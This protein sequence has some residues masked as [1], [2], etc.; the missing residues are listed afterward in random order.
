MKTEQAGKLKLVEILLLLFLAAFLATGALALQT[1]QEL[2][3][4]VV[5]LHV[6]ANSDSEEDQAL[7]LQV[8]DRVLAYAEP[9]LAGAADRR[10]AEALLRGRVL[11]LERIAAEE[12]RTEG[13]DYAVT[14]E[15]EDTVFPTREYEDFTLPAGKYLALRVVIGA[16]EGRNWWCV[17]FPPLCA[18]ASAE[19]PEAALAAGLSPAQVGLITEEDQGYVLKSKLVEFW[20]GLEG[21]LD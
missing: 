1:G 12:I 8:R 10:E 15:L 6:L 17:V 19:V 2:S 5:R 11:E 14:V 4:K 7:K 21:K 9:L 16:G 3:D 18:A 20:R 13:Y